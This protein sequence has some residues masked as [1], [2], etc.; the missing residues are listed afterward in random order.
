MK[1]SIINLKYFFFSLSFFL[2]QLSRYDFFTDIG[3]AVTCFK[4]DG[5]L[6]I[7]IASIIII[8][9]ISCKNFYEY[10]EIF[11]QKKML[12]PTGYLNSVY[13]V[14]NIIE[15]N[16]LNEVLDVFCSYC[17]MKIPFINIVLSKRIFN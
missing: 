8:F 9:I 2:S 3:F 1:R 15:F 17:V 12:I 16:A 13:E 11:H 7:G 14:A 6:N 5:N 10:S 4:C